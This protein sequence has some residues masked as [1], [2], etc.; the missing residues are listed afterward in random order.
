MS[1]LISEAVARAYGTIL[2]VA[3]IDLGGGAAPP[4]SDKILMVMK[5]VL[6]I[7][8]AACI[9]GFLTLGAKMAL[10]HR[11]HEG[12]EHASGLGYVLGGCVLIGSASGIVATLLP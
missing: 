10:Q 5:W 3:P 7:V 9:V 12:G 4:G 11:R 8:T 6:Y 2:L 1:T